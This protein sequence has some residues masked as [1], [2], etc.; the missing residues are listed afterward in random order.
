[1]EPIVRI[2]DDDEEAR[3]STAF[4]LTMAG[5]C[6]QTYESA[7]SFLDNDDVSVPGCILLDIRMPGMTGMELQLKLSEDHVELPII[8]CPATEI[9]RWRFMPSA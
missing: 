3:E 5:W 6:T 1:M 9:C 4:L 7:Q 2:I 8:F